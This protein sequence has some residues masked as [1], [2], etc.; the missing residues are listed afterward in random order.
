MSVSRSRHP[1]GACAA[2]ACSILAS[3]CATGSGA[4]LPDDPVLK[5]YEPKRWVGTPKSGLRVIV[6]EDH[7]SPLV[8]LVTSVGVGATADP[9]GVEGLAHFIEHLVFRSKPFG[10][11]QQY[12][13]LLKRTGGFF[14]ASTSWD[15]TTYY[16]TAHKDQLELLMRLE[17]W[18][19][20]NTI[21]GVTAEVF[22]TEREVVRNELRQRWETTPGNKMFDLLFDS[23][24]PT[25]HPLR[26]PVGGTHESLSAARLEH[27]QAFVKQHYKPDNVVITIVGDVKTEDIKRILGTWPAELLFGPGGPEGPPAPMRKRVGERPAPPVPPPVT[28]QLARHKGPIDKP[29][30]LL[31]WSLPPGLRGHDA[32]GRFA[33]SRLNRALGR[34]DR[35][36]EDDIMGGG[37]SAMPLADSSVMVMTAELRPWADP[38]RARKRL[39]DI[40]VHAWADQAIELTEQ[41]S[42]RVDKMSTESMRWASATSLLLRAAE[43]L[44]TAA[45]LSEYMAATGKH[46]YFKEQLEELAHIK[47]SDVSEFAQRWLTRERAVAVYF[48]PESDKIPLVAAGGGGGGRGTGGQTGGESARHDIGRGMNLNAAEFSDEKLLQMVKSPGL[49]KVPHFT[50]SNGLEI[51][52]IEKP[53]SPVANVQLG[54]RGGNVSVKP[55]GAAGLADS[56]AQPMCQQYKDVR[57]VGGFVGGGVGM[58][59]SSMS[60]EALAGNLNNAL[61]AVRDS[62][63]CVEVSEEIFLHVPRLLAQEGK[64]FDRTAVYPDF[65]A[66]KWF[67]AQLYPGHPFGEAG[68]VSPVELKDM[69]REDA[70][71]FVSS[72]YRPGNA[73]AVVYGGVSLDEVKRGSEQY[74]TSWRAGAGGASLSVPPAP[75]GPSARE[76]H[77]VN[78]DKATQ[79]VVSIG[80]RLAPVTPETI[81]AYEVLEAVVNESAWAI[82][83]QYGATYG[84]HAG[85]R[86]NADRSAHLQLGGAIENR[87]AGPSIGRLLKVMEAVGTGTIA[88][89]LFLTK[90]WD[91][92]REF[93]NGFATAGAQ[94]AAIINAKLTGLPFEAY[95]GYPGNLARTRRESLKQIMA[96]CLGKEV[97]AIVGDASVLKPQLEAEGL[98]VSN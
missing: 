28:T 96:P 43:P 66:Q 93:V 17:A 25:G 52:V 63:S 27:A 42:V 87:Q 5:P 51:Y 33:A 71:A 85:V 7:S 91:V 75:D 56:L 29:V 39:L 9:Q 20:L 65:I 22:D 46:S 69:R 16:T 31:A 62:V 6:Q 35:R 88:E 34:L 76:I 44:S 1:R 13:D 37:A 72:L 8:S 30:L 15:F 86:R 68:F 97:I 83:E 55:V 50:I 21:G 24:Y 92:G 78:R 95:D 48:E 3:A 89:P 45:D 67:N 64:V 32:I 19:V 41:T 14:N 53:E 59:N 40:L 49:A 58:T 98:K 70:Q 82:R 26:R 2:L 11:D 80:C 60:A 10:G 47:S 61:A 4:G 12:W 18:R 73:V 23:L 90:R 84:V 94:A 36:E 79:A 81:P 77:L 54:L 74:L 38:E 57:E